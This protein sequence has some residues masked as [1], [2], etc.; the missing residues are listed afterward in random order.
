MY[1]FVNAYARAR[2]CVYIENKVNRANIKSTFMKDSIKNLTF[3]FSL[4]YV[5]FIFSMFRFV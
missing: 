2:A 1:S 5:S 4:I 3:L